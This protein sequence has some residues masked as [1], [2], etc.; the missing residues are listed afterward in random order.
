MKDLPCLVE[1][2]I[3]PEMT[4]REQT[5]AACSDRYLAAAAYDKAKERYPGR[6]IT[7]SNRA[8]ILAKSLND[9][10]PSSISLFKQTDD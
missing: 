4:S 3:D 7:L 6:M 1:L 5:L 8:M 9:P 2:W 10:P